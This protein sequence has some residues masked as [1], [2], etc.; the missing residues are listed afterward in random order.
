MWCQGQ[1]P[2]YFK[3]VTIV[4]L[5]KRK[6]NR[7]RCHNHRGISLLNIAGKIFT[8]ILLTRLNGHLEQGLLQEKCQEIRTH[9]YTT[10]V[11]LTGNR[12]GLW[13]VMQKFC[14]PA[15]FTHMPVW[16][17]D[18]VGSLSGSYQFPPT[19]S[20]A[21][22]SRQHMWR[23]G[24]TLEGSGDSFASAGDCTSPTLP[25][26]HNCQRHHNF[27]ESRGTVRSEH[28]DGVTNG[29]PSKSDEE[30]N[31]DGKLCAQ[32]QVRWVE[33]Q[34]AKVRVK[35]D[36]GVFPNDPKWKDMWYL[37]RGGPGGIDMNVRSVWARGFAGQGVVVTI[38]DD[39]LETDHPDLSPNYDKLASLDVNGN[40][41]NPHPRYV[42]RDYR[43]TKS[44]RC[45]RL[46]RVFGDGH[47]TEAHTSPSSPHPPAAAASL[48]A[49]SQCAILCKVA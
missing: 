25:L 46:L 40:D 13:N 18:S 48:C 2:Q 22:V 35:R 9:L 26:F 16:G 20:N 12:D 3:D 31:S 1:F 17:P 15:R 6:G 10:F 47:L 5:Y 19:S 41:E 42:V 49:S 30:N 27:A 8:H 29:V 37:N 39:G 11:D 45:N 24:I 7:Q 4:Y 28:A 33:Q 34:V 36:L 44:A 14:Y 43:N 21:P 38:L 32:L 23:A